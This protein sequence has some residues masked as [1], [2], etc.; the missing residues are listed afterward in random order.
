MWHAISPV[1]MS[2]RQITTGEEF[3]ADRHRYPPALL[4]EGIKRVPT[5]HAI[6]FVSILVSSTC[7]QATWPNRRTGMVLGMRAHPPRLPIA[8]DT[9]MW[10]RQVQDLVRHACWPWVTEACGVAFRRQNVYLIP[11][12]YGVNMPGYQQWVEAAN[13]YLADRLL[14]GTAFPITPLKPMVEAFRKLPFRADVR[15]KVEYKNAQ[16]LLRLAQ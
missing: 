10:T 6:R 3:S 5:R 12:A 1:E 15:E 13:T 8:R 2:Y 7:R 11:D 9:R 16:K 14:F 4:A